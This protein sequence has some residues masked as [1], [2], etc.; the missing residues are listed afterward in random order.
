V[1]DFHGYFF[2][3]RAF[4]DLGGRYFQRAGIELGAVCGVRRIAFFKIIIAF[5]VFAEELFS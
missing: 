5:F 4:D 1:P 3:S 2:S